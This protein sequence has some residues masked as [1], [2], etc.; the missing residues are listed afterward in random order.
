MV[1]AVGSLA[2]CDPA[3]KTVR[4]QPPGPVT[5]AGPAAPVTPAA[6]TTPPAPAGSTA[7]AAPAATSPP[8]PSAPATGASMACGSWSQEGSTTA[9]KIAA[10]HGEIRNCALVGTT[11]VVTTLGTGTTSGAILLQMCRTTDSRCLDGSADR[12]A[13]AFTVVH[14]PH[15]GGVTLLATSPPS[16]IIVDNGGS[17]LTFHIPTLMFAPH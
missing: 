15:P 7:P 14:P 8:A 6:P 4:T 11:W 13:S 16:D 17:E 12:S 1:L 3:P 9:T 2:A 10:A 5:P